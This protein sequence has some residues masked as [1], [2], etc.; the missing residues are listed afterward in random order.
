MPSGLPLLHMDALPYHQQTSRNV[1]MAD[2]GVATSEIMTGHFVPPPQRGVVRH[3]E[4]QQHQDQQQQQPHA[5]I[6]GHVPSHQQ[7]RTRGPV[8][9]PTQHSGQN[10]QQLY[11]HENINGQAP[12]LYPH[13]SPSRI[14]MA[15]NGNAHQSSQILSSIRGHLGVMSTV[16]GES[17]SSNTIPGAEPRT[18][19]PK[20]RQK[21]K[22]DALSNV[23][24]S[25]Y[26]K[27][28]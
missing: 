2:S 26:N 4:Q 11:R 24:S 5:G 3:M 15:Q 14:F 22:E 9:M 27:S 8:S 1:N 18:K 10:G 20:K 25:M 7:S 19:G 16:A 6:S 28:V 13:E 12:L 17:V 23:P 21:G